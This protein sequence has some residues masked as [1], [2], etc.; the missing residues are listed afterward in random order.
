MYTP[1]T[2]YEISKHAA[3]AFTDSL[4][5]ELKTFGIQVVAANPSFHSTPLV[6][7]AQDFMNGDAV[8]N[9]L[10]AEHKKE[11]G[12]DFVHDLSRHVL[13][14]MNSNVWD[15]KVAVD[16]MVNALQSSSPPAQLVIGMDARTISAMLRMFPQWVRHL[17]TMLLLPNLTPH[18]MKSKRDESKS[19]LE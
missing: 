15:S 2:P 13:T 7:T 17:I 18:I 16:C 10:S 14:F 19:K 6:T 11:Y 5:L 1:G 12:Q 8:W 4:R 9:K 3:E